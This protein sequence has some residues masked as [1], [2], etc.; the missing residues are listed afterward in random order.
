MAQ[1]FLN[2]EMRA[3]AEKGTPIAQ[4]VTVKGGAVGSIQASLGRD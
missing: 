1:G 3:V 4:A 2:Y